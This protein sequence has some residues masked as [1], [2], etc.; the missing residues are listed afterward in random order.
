MALVF[1][2]G[3][4]AS[5][6]QPTR[7][8]YA[9]RTFSGADIRIGPGEPTTLVAVF[10]TWCTTCRNEFAMLDSLQ[11][12]LAARGIRVLALSVDEKDDAHVRRYTDARGTRVPIARDASGAVGK[13]FGTVGVPETYLVD[14]KG[15]IRW[16]GRG[17]LRMGIADLRRALK[18]LD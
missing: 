18:D 5:F 3:A 11:A 13:T 1:L 16:R 15:V 10:A 2:L 12:V 14:S 4:R 8:S 9:T 7:V 17:D 6:A